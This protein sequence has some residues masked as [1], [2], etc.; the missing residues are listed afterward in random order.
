MCLVNTHA[1][2][3]TYMRIYM[4]TR[5]HPH[6]HPH[7]HMHTHARTRTSAGASARKVL[8]SFDCWHGSS[9]LLTLRSKGA[10]CSVD[11][12]MRLRVCASRMQLL[13]KTQDDIIR[14]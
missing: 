11:K 13:L 6:P 8:N 12:T 2:A 10:Q 4:H 7:P 5:A 9:I 1:Q 3:Y 14:R